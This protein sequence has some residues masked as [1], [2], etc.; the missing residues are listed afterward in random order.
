VNQSTPRNKFNW[1]VARV[2]F[3]ALALSSISGVSSADTIGFDPEGN[4]SFV[5]VD[6]FDFLPGNTLFRDIGS[7]LVD[8]TDQP[9]AHYVQTRLG[10]LIDG[11]GDPIST[12]GLNTTYEL[13]IVVNFDS[14]AT[15]VG[16]T[17]LYGLD[18]GAT[19]KSLQLYYDDFSSGTQA[20]DLAGTG[21]DDG[22]LILDGDIVSADGVMSFLDHSTT[23]TL[24]QFNDDDY[25][26]VDT[27]IA[28]GALDAA[29]E[30]LYAD[31]DFFDTL[32]P[33]LAMTLYNQSEITPFDQVDPSAV[34]FDN[35]V[36][37]APNIGA[38]NGA[39]SDF[40][41]QSDS[42]SSFVVVENIIPEPSTL[43]LAVFGLTAL[44]GFQ[45]RLRRGNIA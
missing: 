9:N 6:A 3:L 5:S 24:D 8:K 39:G 21:F 42:N 38:I 13:T 33:Y 7:L 12:P 35:T 22:L 36:N 45:K 16:T 40:Q 31:M 30:V 4:A 25:P 37:Y 11:N 29:I 17:T 18:P 14:L 2:A 32:P 20:D 23:T 27:Y 15:T 19:I 43:T 41:V 10:S 34:F 28:F 44:A 1:R 26:G